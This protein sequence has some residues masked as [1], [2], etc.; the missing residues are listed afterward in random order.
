MEVEFRPTV[1]AYRGFIRYS[2]FR[3][4]IGLKIALAGLVSFWYGFVSGDRRSFWHLDFQIFPAL[5]AGIFLFL[6]AT[7]VPFIIAHLKTRKKLKQLEGITFQLRIELTGDGFLVQRMAEAEPEQEKKFWRWGAVNYVGGSAKYVF[8]VLIQ[9]GVYVIPKAAFQSAEEA[10]HFVFILKAGMETVW[11]SK[12]KRAN[13]FYLWGL[14]GLIPNVGLVAGLILLFKGIFK[15]RDK[16]LILIGASDILITIIFWWVIASIDF[17]NIGFKSL[18]LQMTHSRLNTIFRYVEFYKIQHGI[19]PD[20]LQQ[21]DL[22]RDDI[23]IVDPLDNWTLFG[24]EHKTVNF[25]YQKIGGKYWLFSVGPDGK[26]FTADDIYPV[27]NPADS[28][29]FGIMK[30]FVH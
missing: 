4:Y 10:N 19:Y 18:N 25:F 21:M 1:E 27:M 17:S 22:E 28:A 3:R 23:W 20:S 29:K 30:K 8:I 5:G 13:S 16:I 7:G 26:P 24:P 12:P 9:G 2:I 15:F 11:G 6:C 14:L